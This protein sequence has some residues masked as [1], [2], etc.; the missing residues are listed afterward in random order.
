MSGAVPGT[1]VRF[2]TLSSSTCDPQL[3]MWGSAECSLVEFMYL[4]ATHWV[5][6][7]EKCCS[8]T[9][10]A[11]LLSQT[12]LGTL[13]HIFFQNLLLFYNKEKGALESQ[14]SA[15]AEVQL[16]PTSGVF[17]IPLLKIQCVTKPLYGFTCESFTHH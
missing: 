17:L 5:V 10:F 11:S 16:Q 14:L 3:V 4:K 2:L 12:K 13:K 8:S 1:W 9:G 7:T 15:L 6:H